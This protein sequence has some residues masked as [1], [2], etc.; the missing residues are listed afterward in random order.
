MKK[1]LKKL[2]LKHDVVR[3]LQAENLAYAAG[4]NTSS[5]TTPTSLIPNGCKTANTICCD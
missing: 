3:Q 1:T 5:V 2:H 4:G